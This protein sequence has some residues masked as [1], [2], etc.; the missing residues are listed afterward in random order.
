[1]YVW[2]FNTGRGLSVC[3]RFPHNIGLVYD[4]GASS[5]FSPTRF[6]EKNIAAKLTK[7]KDVSIA[8]TVLSHPHAD[9]IL[10]ID[11]IQAGKSLCPALITCP[12]DRDLEG[13]VSQE[14]VDFS[15]LQNGT[16]AE[17]LDAYRQSYS[18]RRPPLQTLQA[19]DRS[20]S[21]Y[22]YVPTDVEYGLYYLRPPLVSQLHR[23]SDQDYGNGL[24]LVLY[25]RY[26][27]QTLLLTGDITPDVLRLVLAGQ[28][29]VEKRYTFFRS[30]PN[31]PGDFHCRTSSQP[32]LRDL[33]S[34][35]GL[36]ALVA[37]HHGLESCYCPE[38]FQAIRGGKTSI[39]LISEKR[40]GPTEGSVDC[41][42]QSQET[43][44]GT[45]VDADGEVQH[46]FSVSTRNG[47]H[48]LLVLEGTNPKPRVYLRKN[49]FDLLTIV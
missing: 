11:A 22:S 1:M 14:K 4:L 10:E 37:P 2:I 7:Y 25:L 20:S 9:H 3:V 24:S 38:L 40:Q 49:A 27:Q 15:R 47:H 33:L 19:P 35:Y 17:L 34:Q 12:N 45:R 43:S 21:L 32:T 46:R 26:G 13:G 18:A 16:N 44:F 41:R 29:G 36:T 31:V 5:D 6:V 30:K 39:N 48:I 28:G 42:Y 8:Q 23:S